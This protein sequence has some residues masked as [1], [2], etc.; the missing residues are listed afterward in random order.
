MCRDATAVTHSGPEEYARHV[1]P[2]VAAAWLAATRITQSPEAARCLVRTG[3]FSHGELVLPLRVE[4]AVDTV[5]GWTAVQS[6]I[7]RKERA[8]HR[9]VTRT[10]SPSFSREEGWSDVERF[11]ETMYL[12]TMASLHGD[13]ARVMTRE[14]L[15]D[16]FALGRVT[17]LQ[18]QVDGAIVAGAL[19]LRD[20]T[21]KV[22]TGRLLGVVGGRAELR[23]LGVFDVLYFEL[24]RMAADTGYGSFNMSGGEPFLSSGTLQHKRRYGAHVTAAPGPLGEAGITLE[25]SGSRTVANQFLF[26]NP[27]LARGAG[28]QLVPYYFHDQNTGPRLELRPP[29]DC[30]P[31]VVV[32]VDLERPF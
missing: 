13:Y 24:L 10:L 4:L 20:D 30:T 17:L 32:D 16:E 2:F 29:R 1:L 3:E 23:K 9:R 26:D 25:F 6:A 22:L 28:G 5:D 19:A 21:R 11:Y 8:H 18:M 12:P 15:D 14:T 27:F 7:S 31:P